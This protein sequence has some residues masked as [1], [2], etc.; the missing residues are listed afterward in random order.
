ME[1]DQGPSA[2]SDFRGLAAT[3]RIDGPPGNGFG[4]KPFSLFAP[5]VS[6]VTHGPS[7]E[8]P[9]SPTIV[10][11]KEISAPIRWPPPAPW[12]GA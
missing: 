3:L 10:T 9:S 2:P 1:P 11:S 7:G 4:R 5:A 6:T 8:E 12:P